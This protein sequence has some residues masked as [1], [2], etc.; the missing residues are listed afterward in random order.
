MKTLPSHYR[1]ILLILAVLVLS[2]S[3]YLRLTG[4]VRNICGNGVMEQKEQCDDGDNNNHDGCST[5]C[6]VLTGWV[7]SGSLSICHKSCG[8]TIVE[9]R[10]GEECDDGG[11]REKD[12]CSRICKAEKGFVCTGDII[13]RCH[14]VKTAKECGLSS[15]GNGLLD[16]GEE[17]DNGY[18]NGKPTD[19]CNLN[20]SVKQG[21][22]C[23]GTP[24][25][26]SICS[27]AINVVL[28]E[29]EKI[30]KGVQ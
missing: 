6:W 24:G 10:W 29:Q 26:R 28:E 30:R 20:C 14:C 15:C 16:P 11:N 9:P 18:M 8:N 4:E 12:G 25:G 13:S 22:T 23:W 21:Y 7:C 1:I 3:T 2:M 27:R 17:C 19:A 5:G